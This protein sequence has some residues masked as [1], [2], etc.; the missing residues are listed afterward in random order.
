MHFPAGPL[1]DAVRGTLVLLL[2]A[3]IVAPASLE[4]QT[5]PFGKNK[6]QYREFDWRV[7]QGE[8]VDVYYYP[9]EE[10][11]ARLAL[12]DAE[13]SYRLLERKFQHHPFRRIP[14]IVYSSHQHFE[15][16]NVTSGFIPEGVLGFTEYLKRRVA[17]PFRGD[18]AQFKHT[19]LHELVHAFQISKLAQ[20]NASLARGSGTSPQQV[21]WWTEGLAEYWSSEQTTEDEMFVRDLVLNGRLPTISRF[22]S[23][24]SYASYPLGAELHHY[25]AGRFGE[26][27]ILRAYEDYWKY[28]D[29]PALL[30]G[31]LQVDLDQLSREWH[32]ALE[33]RFFPIYGDRPPLE[34]GSRVVIEEGGANFKPTP[35][36]APGDTATHLLF[37]SPRSGYT[38]IYRTTLARG[39]RGVRT[40]V[41]GERSDEFESFH[42]YE[43]SID[44]SGAGMLTF[45]S[46]FQERDALFVWDLERRE[47]T[48]RYQWDDLVGLKSPSWSPD[49]RAVV[50]EGL[51]TAGFSDLYVL[52]FDTQERRQL[53]DDRFRDE[54]PDWSPD[55]AT[56][57]FAS[58]RT[59]F[60][61]D[62]YRNLYLVDLAT[63][64]VQPLTYGRWND[65]SPAWSPDGG[66][67][68]FSSDRTGIFD[69]YSVDRQGSGVRLTSMTGGAFDPA[70]LPDGSGLVYAGFSEGRFRIFQHP[71]PPDTADLA[72]IALAPEARG[73][74]AGTGVLALASGAA[75]TDGWAW[76]EGTRVSADSAASKPYE[77]WQRLSLDFA[78]GE[79]IV[80]PGVGSAQG[81]QFLLSD[82]LGDQILFFGI[83][84]FQ[85]GRVDDLVDSFSG[86]LL[87]LNLSRRLNYGGGVFRFKGRYR[88]VAYNVYDEETYGASVV[89]SYPF[90]RFRRL[91]FQ[92]G[93]ERSER[94]DV[95]DACERG[96]LCPT[97]RS[98]PRDLTRSGLLSTNLVSFVKDNTLW[99]PT[100]P[101]DG[102]R[103]NLTA[104]LTTCFECKRPS[105]A[106]STL[107]NR[108]TLLEHYL[109]TADLRRYLRVTL[110][111][112]YA[113]RLYGYYSD[114]A[115]PGRAVLGGPHRLRGYPLFSLAGSRLWLLNQEYRFPI[116]HGLALA[117]PIGELRFPGIQ[118]AFF[119]DLGSSWLEGQDYESAWGS[120]GMGFRTSLGAPLVLRLDVGKRFEVGEEPPVDFGG[121]EEFGDTFVDFFFGY[122]F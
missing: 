13:D 57:V 34:V 76:S 66:R 90:S 108:G 52:D 32:Y 101:I 25:L 82:M 59:P 40:V 35:W 31:I 47:V 50:F 113:V 74:G 95:P 65:Q 118:G 85:T 110:R 114:G 64:A 48:G 120:Y 87:Y 45:I 102:G 105:A 103:Y 12:A 98:D 24:Y 33:Q 54:D 61:R 5:V 22:S 70:W 84:A 99:L 11:L 6:I 17:L 14:L 67:V 23:M 56:I 104:G 16:T 4:A 58:D 62:G 91:E 49:G 1:R 94:V 37:L 18:Y 15:Q 39:E 75:A 20:V 88:D 29:F 79:G 19:L 30:E 36:V 78:G 119:T 73:L 46:K 122:N 83:S 9:E 81:A 7:L 8:H 117:F 106:D 89:A 71:L 2:A 10:A 3:A 72:P 38:N 21:H 60:G 28:P 107:T 121:D 100:G 51:T 97:K 43:S 80:V 69:L 86:Q 109:L 116:L 42:A 27:Y 115:I 93:L 111:S 63:R 96:I 26:E 112:A 55:G 68:L 92:L 53:T 77:S 44:V 41:E